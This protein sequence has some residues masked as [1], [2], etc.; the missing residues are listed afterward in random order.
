MKKLNMQKL[1]EL[2][3]AR[4]LAD[5]ESG[6]VGGAALCVAQNGEILL[7]KTYG[8]QNATTKEPLRADAMFRL[9]SMTK[10]I[11]AVAALIAQEQGLLSID[12]E[13]CKYIPAY[14]HMKIGHM[15]NGQP[16]YDKDAQTPITIKH[17]LSHTSGIGTLEIGDHAWGTMPEENSKTPE[18]VMEW[19]SDK[20]LAFEPYT[21]Q[22]YSPVAAFVAVARIIEIVS[23][24]AYNEYLDKYLFG[25]L[26]MK[27]TTFDL[28]EDQKAR[29][30]AMHN[31]TEEQGGF[32]VPKSVETIFENVPNTQCCGGAGLAAT[33]DDYVKFGEMLTLGGTLD[34]VRII[35]PESVAQMATVQVTDAIMP[36]P[37]QWGLGVRVI[38]ADG[39]QMP[40][41]CFGWSGAYGTHYWSD[42]EN[43]ITAIYMK[44]SGYD[45]GAGALTSFM[46][47]QDV[48][49]AMEG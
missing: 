28:N 19:L 49:A 10:P 6:K 42:P 47:E 46:F 31:Y 30:I 27:D 17:L 43:K 11:T 26:G 7:H 44:N 33:L 45:G 4:V 24:M 13:L 18:G 12:D 16:V 40:K 3:D 37:I 14:A 36:P 48:Y 15:E 23:G 32:A 34:G 21:A 41:G 22:W 20:M 9:A 39:Y 29:M 2:V 1:N 5:I 8:Y 25:P 38:S 35:S